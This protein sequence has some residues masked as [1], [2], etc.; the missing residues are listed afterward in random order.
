MRMTTQKEKIKKKKKKIEGEQET[1][2]DTDI[3]SRVHVKDFTLPS[4]S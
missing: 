1:L 2:R 3:I 4:L